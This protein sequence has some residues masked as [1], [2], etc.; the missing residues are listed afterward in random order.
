MFVGDRFFTDV[1]FGN[2][3]GMLTIYVEPFTSKGDNPMV[4][5][6]RS[7]EAE[8]VRI[9]EKHSSPPPHP[10]YSKELFANLDDK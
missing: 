1:V 7:S 5:F 2:S 3:H 9:W 6:M 8:L 10:L 4:R